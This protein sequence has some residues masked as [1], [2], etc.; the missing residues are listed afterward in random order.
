MQISKAG[1]HRLIDAMCGD[2]VTEADLER[3][4]E[5]VNLC[6]AEMPVPMV[7]VR[8]RRRRNGETEDEAATGQT[9]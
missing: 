5:T 2:S 8:R 7:E 9:A 1:L 4:V 3:V 6:Q